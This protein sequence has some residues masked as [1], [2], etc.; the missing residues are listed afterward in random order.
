VSFDTQYL[1]KICLTIEAAERTLGPVHAQALIT[2]IADDFFGFAAVCREDDSLFLPV[3][4]SYRARFVAVGKRFA[5]D[6]NGK[7]VWSSIKRL[8]LTEIEG[9]NE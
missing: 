5:C 8:K 1:Q 7:V 2:L 3:G 9:I 6:A 4:A